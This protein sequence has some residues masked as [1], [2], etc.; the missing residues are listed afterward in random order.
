MLIYRWYGSLPAQGSHF[1]KNKS[2][3]IVLTGLVS[4]L[5]LLVC[6]ISKIKTG[7]ISRHK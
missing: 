3:T 5:F 7:H 6:K 1:N 2:C 4:K